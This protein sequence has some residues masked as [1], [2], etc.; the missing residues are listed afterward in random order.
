MRKRLHHFLPGIRLVF[1]LALLSSLA[2]CKELS[3]QVTPAASSPVTVIADRQN[4]TIALSP[5]T[6]VQE[7][8]I[9]AN[10]T[11]SN[12]DR[13][14]PP[15]YSALIGGETIKVVR[16]REEFEISQVIIP[17]EQ[18]VVR[19][20]SLP[21]DQKIS[22]QSGKNGLQEDTIRHLFEDG[23]EVSKTTVKSTIIKEPVPE[24]EM[25]GVQTPFAPISISGRLAYLIGG[26]AWIMENNTSSRRPLITSGNLD[27]RVFSLSPNGEWLLY[28]IHPDASDTEKIN[29]LW[30]IRTIGDNNKPIDLKV[31]NVIHFADWVPGY[32]QTFSYSTVEPR[33][34]AP[35]W[36]ANNDF[37]IKSFKSTGELTEPKQI[38]EPNAGGL[39]GWWG[40]S[41]AW[42]PDGTKL[43]YARPES[44]GFVNLETGDFQPAVSI[45]PFQTHSDWAWTPSISWAPDQNILFTITHQPASGLI[46]PEESP[47][48]DTS[49][50]PLTGGAVVSLA[51]QSGMFSYPSASHADLA[52]DYWL[53]FLQ[54][55]FPE[56]S[57][58]SRYRLV[59][60][61]R[62]GSNRRVVFPDSG[63]AGLDPQQPVWSP[64]KATSPLITIIY[65]GNLYLIDPLTNQSH[66]IT[67]DGLTS[68]IDWK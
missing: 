14:T 27:G 23:V 59:I 49:A 9:R 3:P 8:L 52:G 17:F 33:S 31:S 51:R 12:L 5:G 47:I 42:S 29:S 2:A 63:A 66:Q 46:S 54:A 21:E 56:Q 65:Q 7:A 11:L 1:F 37:Y 62:D 68:R 40:T 39:Y 67:G 32:S 41:F 16:V 55:I 36:Q 13:V 61:D 6:T 26:S 18:Q 24:I 4:Q 53:A 48:F 22:I 35:G 50:Y 44:V 20:E 19:N 43:A 15:S 38:I 58:T 57:E 60:M 45:T 30:V 10:I 28:S 34:T 64:Q 25:V